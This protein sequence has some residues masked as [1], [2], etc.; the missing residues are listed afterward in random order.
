MTKTEARWA[1]LQ[2]FSRLVQYAEAHHLPFIVTCFNRSPDEQRRLV[3]A[4]KSK[5]KH[6]Q[7]QEWLAMDLALVN[8]D[9]ELTWEHTFGDGYEALGLYWMQLSIHARWGGTFGRTP[10]EIG[11]DPYHFEFRRDVDKENGS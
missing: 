4:G 3:A 9:G 7:H 10:D 6:S 2:A 1:F 8:P 11:W 5:V